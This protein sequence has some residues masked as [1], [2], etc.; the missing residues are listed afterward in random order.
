M[1]CVLSGRHLLRWTSRH[2]PAL[3]HKVVHVVEPGRV[4]Q[5]GSRIPKDVNW[6]RLNQGCRW[7]R[8]DPKIQVESWVR[9]S[10][11]DG[12]CER[13]DIERG[14]LHDERAAER[15]CEIQMHVQHGFRRVIRENLVCAHYGT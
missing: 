3:N 15:F 10:R 11:H 8:R 1:P 12:L 6:R 14:L 7:L 2:D 4:N 5:R 13:R 9:R